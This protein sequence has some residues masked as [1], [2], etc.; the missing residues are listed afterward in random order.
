M[1]KAII[2]IVLVMAAVF[3]GLF[4][5][6]N[7]SRTGMPDDSVLRRAQKRARELAATEHAEDE[8]RRK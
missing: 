8:R 2:V 5:L 1:L 4:V 3:G 6:R 7:S